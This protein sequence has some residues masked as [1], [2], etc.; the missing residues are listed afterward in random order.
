MAAS[1]TASATIAEPSTPLPLHRLDLD[2]YNKIVASGALE[3]R[4]VELLHGLLVEM[5]PQSPTHAV[6]I[7]RLTHHFASAKARMRVQLPIE[8]PVDSEPEPDIALL[9]HEPG[10][11]EHPRTALLAVEVAVSSQ[12]KDRETKASLYSFAGIPTY[13]LVDVPARVVEVYSEPGEHGY[14]KCERHGAKVTLPCS[15]EGVPDLDLGKLFDG[16]ES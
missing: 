7:E 12:A 1:A 16:I 14:R 10:L 2:T 9:N 15:V 6:L 11:I 3:G 13:W 8:V 4:R 5:S